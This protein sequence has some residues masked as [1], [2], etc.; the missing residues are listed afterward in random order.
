MSLMVRKTG[1]R[2]SDYNAEFREIIDREF[3]GLEGRQSPQE[4]VYADGGDFTHGEKAVELARRF[5]I[6]L[7]PWQREQVLRA[8]AIDTEGHWLHQDIVLLCPRQNGK[9]LILE[10]VILYRLFVLHHQ[11]VFSAHQWRTAKSIR[12]RIWKKIK[13]DLTPVW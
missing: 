8:L 13:S 7:I 12:N 9:S 2:G 6:K 4:Y 11:I 5:G 1:S 10:V 3:P